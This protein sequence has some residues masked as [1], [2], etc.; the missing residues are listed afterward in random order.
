[1][2]YV[3][4][5]TELAATID[6]A[7]TA[8]RLL[9]ASSFEIVDLETA[10]ATQQALTA[11][12]LQRE[13]RIAGW[14]LGYTSTAMRMQM[15]IAAP[16]YGPLLDTMLI[17]SKSDV[18]GQSVQ[19]KVEPEIALR[20]AEPV[21]VDADRDA[22]LAAVGSV[23]ACLEVVDSVWDGYRFTLAHNTADGSSA[24]A[25]VIGP[26]LS[27]DWWLPDVS[28]ELVKNGHPVA[29]ATG[30]A[31]SGHPADGVVWLAAQLAERGL[32]IEAD[33]VV[34][35]GGLTAAV[36]LDYG[37]IVSAVFNDTIHVSVTRAER[38]P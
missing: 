32:R 35:T 33:D 21:P 6:D 7:H 8:G 29:S 19:P 3:S 18:S 20:F 34:I 31:A 17:E 30:A 1:M 28:V 2:T 23:H 16:N 9:D 38:V 11:L 4:R 22:V 26:E 36:D 25:A 12:R 14:K 24:C 10:Y 15:G 27:R 5:I 13:G 37:D